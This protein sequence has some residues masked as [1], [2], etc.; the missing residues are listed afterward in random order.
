MDL[1]HTLSLKRIL[2][3]WHFEMAYEGQGFQL[4]WIKTQT[5]GRKGRGSPG[6]ENLT[7][8]SL[9][10]VLFSMDTAKGTGKTDAWAGGGGQGRHADIKNTNICVEYCVQGLKISV[11]CWQG[12]STVLL[13]LFFPFV[14]CIHHIAPSWQLQS[15]VMPEQQP[16]RSP[17]VYSA[18]LGT[19]TLP[20]WQLWR[21][22]DTLCFYCTHKLPVMLIISYPGKMSSPPPPPFF[23]FFSVHSK[24]PFMGNWN[25]MLVNSSLPLRAGEDV[26]YFY[27][28]MLFLA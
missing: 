15:T 12:G 17:S 11:C 21:P 4:P 13:W 18:C 1:D 8:A 22:K 26:W 6:Q 9:L 2:C 10:G 25:P 3:H 27:L 23:F 24:Y 5:N 16:C 28:F 7:D 14:K 20:S 19:L